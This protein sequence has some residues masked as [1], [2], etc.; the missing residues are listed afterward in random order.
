MSK[1]PSQTTSRMVV[2]RIRSAIGRHQEI[3]KT[4]NLLR[5]HKTNH[6]V[7]I[8]DRETYKGMLQKAKDTV[9]WGE[10]NF[11]STKELIIK[12]GRINGNQRVTE[13]Y[14][15]KNTRFS[16]IDDFVDQFLRFK[17]SLDEIKGLKPVFRLHPP[18]KGYRS[19][20][21]KQP[22][23]LGGALGYRGEHINQLIIKMA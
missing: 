8:D 1:S 3:K 15:K 21:V 23:T 18:R 13:D 22:Y 16:N 5:L 12:R 11:A 2:I 9:T 20:G 4:L 7:I 17:A 6:C 19:R 10:L 14:I